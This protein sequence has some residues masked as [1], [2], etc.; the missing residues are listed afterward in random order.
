MLLPSILPAL[1]VAGTKQ[2]RIRCGVGVAY[3]RLGSPEVRVAH[4][5]RDR[6]PQRARNDGRVGPIVRRV[7]QQT[8]LTALAAAFENAALRWFPAVPF[9]P[10]CVRCRVFVF[11]AKIETKGDIKE[12][13]Y[14]R[15]FTI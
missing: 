13:C 2:A 4:T 14:V 12:L 6:P 11:L 10:F 15:Y 7:G 1:R 8:P 5:G 9:A 3:R